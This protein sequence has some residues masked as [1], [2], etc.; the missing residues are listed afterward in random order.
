[1]NRVEV[2]QNWLAD[3]PNTGCRISIS[4]SV[5]DGRKIFD[6]AG[7]IGIAQGME[8]LLDL[9]E[10]F[11]DRK[12]IGFLFVG[13]GSYAQQLISETKS[14]GLDNTLCYDEIDP[15]EIP[16]LY[17][18]CHVGLVVLDPRHKTHNLPGKFLSYMQS[19]LPVLA[20][21][22]P[23]NDLEKLIA[24]KQIGRVCTNNS[25]DTLKCLAEDLLEDI[26]VDFGMKSRCLALSK[27]MFSPEIAV[28]KIVKALTK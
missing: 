21:I 6:Y 26:S 24:S 27:K 28:N 17:E 18:Q 3:A 15:S 7:N 16:G 11:I 2:L 22:N 20:R 14:R 23:G 8:I 25:V 12:D 4:N 10:K 13:R 1:M 19:G 9:A 5:L